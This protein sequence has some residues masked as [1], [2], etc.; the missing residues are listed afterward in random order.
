[1]KDKAAGTKGCAQAPKRS[2]GVFVW[3]A[4]LKVAVDAT[5]AAKEERSERNSGLDASDSGG[6]EDRSEGK[7]KGGSTSKDEEG[8][9]TDGKRKAEAT[10]Q[11]GKSDR[12]KEKHQE[13]NTKR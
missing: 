5:E 1:M 3:E 7:R 12:Q 9:A 6:Q 11:K 2:Q 4:V 8:K 13:E 10:K